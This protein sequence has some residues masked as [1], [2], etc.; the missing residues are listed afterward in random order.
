M[1]AFAVARTGSSGGVTATVYKLDGSVSDDFRPVS[2]LPYSGRV[3]ETFAS[4]AG[5][6]P[7]SIAMPTRNATTVFVTDRAP[8][9]RLG[10][11]ECNCLILLAAHGH[12]RLTQAGP[13]QGRGT[14]E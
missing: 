12:G 8:I 14:K 6:R 2:I 1:H 7:S 9:A 5:K 3:S 11:P 4:K 13:V 10:A